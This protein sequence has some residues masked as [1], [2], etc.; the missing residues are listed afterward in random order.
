MITAWILYAILVG[1]F[2]G[3]GALAVEHLV[4]THGLPS[5][6][7]WIGAMV[8]SAG[9]PLGHWTWNARPQ[10]PTV[11]APPGAPV[12]EALADIPVPVIPLEPVALEVAPDSVLR[13]LDGPLTLA[14]AATTLALVL[15]FALLI[16]RT[17]HLVRRWRRGQVGGETVLFSDQWGPAVVGFLRPQIVLPA[18]SKDL[19]AWALRFI[20][21]HEMEHVRAGDLRLM[22]LAGVLPVLFPWHL[23][24]WWQLTRLR[25][26]VEGDCD[27]RVLRRNPGQ[28]RPYVNLLLEVGERCSRPSPMVAM[29]SEPFTTLRRRIKIMTMPL[30]RRPWV[31][32][33]LFAGIGTFLVAVACLAPGPT[34][35]GLPGAEAPRES[36]ASGDAGG[37][38]QEK[39][40]PV[41]TPFTVFPGIRN[42]EAVVRAL[43]REY[44]PSL[45]DAGMGGTVLMALYLDEDGRVRRVSLERSSGHGALD[46]IALRAADIIQFSP[47]LNRD[48]K[49]PVWVSLPLEFRARDVEGVGVA[50]TSVGEPV[51]RATVAEAS[52]AAGAEGSDSEPGRLD[53]GTG[54]RGVVAS[55]AAS[56]SDAQEVG[57]VVQEMGEMVREMGEI[58]GVA[59]DAET[60]RPLA[61]VQVFVLGTQR[62]TLSDQDGRFLIRHV[63]VGEQ[64]VVADLIGYGRTS[65]G[66]TVTAEGRAEVAFNLPV[67]A[68]P[69]DRLLVWGRRGG[70]PAR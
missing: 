22:V 13:L 29:L 37:A 33:A 2:V 1:S 5:R 9:W 58:A 53:V 43:E 12:L 67:T 6:W 10:A 4:R 16:L 21:D 66:I 39:S 11:V 7:V 34:E 28:T 27:L 23:P 59:T 30:P 49:R 8:L 3:A 62:G 44:P 45:R 50:A 42:R 17:R 56:P 68:I 24:V 20:L 26:A 38:Q 32:G 31:R 46:R 64:E 60:G 54:A 48:Q 61:G 18:W 51:A 55:S 63:P 14:W 19:D 69:L 35:V 36:L 65:Q 25:S 52:A 57:E 41:F 40:L 70:S 47:A 15:L